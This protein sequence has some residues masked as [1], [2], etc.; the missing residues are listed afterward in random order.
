L[1]S[2]ID[3]EPTMSVSISVVVPTR[4]RPDQVPGC[5]ESILA[6][7][8][9]DYDVVVVDQSDDDATERALKAL[10]EDPRVSYVHSD[11]R[12]VAKARNLGW[13]S[14]T[15]SLILYT[16][17]DCRVPPGWVEG[18]RA[19]LAGDERT[20]IVFGR[21]IVPADVSNGEFAASFEPVDAVHDGDLPGPDEPWGISANMLV[22]SSV[23]EQ[24]GGFD[25]ALGAGG[26]FKSAAETDLMIRAVAAGYRVRDVQEPKVLHYGVRGVDE[27]PKL[28]RGYAFGLGAAFTKHLRLGT[29]PGRFLLP[30]W[31]VFF[32]FR[33]GKN[34]LRRRRPVGIGFLKGLL[35]GAWGSRH[36][37]IDRSTGRYILGAGR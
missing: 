26:R 14:S 10:L 16:D 33:A 9:D 15:G 19:S 1:R 27:A 21:V 11:E 12:G 7:G 6:N 20:S 36:T 17:D 32:S 5:V 29:R 30:R 31:L 3:E 8:G 4:N 34:L 37:A 28:V 35:Q 2:K 24:L 25:D 13:R 18:L 23:L 22:R